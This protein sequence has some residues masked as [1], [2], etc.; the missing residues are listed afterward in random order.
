MNRKVK[1]YVEFEVKR[2][3]ISKEELNTLRE[4]LIESAPLQDGSGIR[5][6][7]NSDVTGSKA[8]Q[9]VTNA[10]LKKLAE[11]VTSIESVV[12]DL[13]EE[14]YR[15]LELRYWKKPRLLNDN[16][17]AEELNIGRSTMY[18]W[19]DG[20]ICAVAKELGMVEE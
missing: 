7:G 15:L 9:L 3:H 19:V 20:I 12:E 16:G 4:D 6:P 5:S 1:D 18:R 2:Y 14:K 11:T 8:V 17:I 10:R 13:D